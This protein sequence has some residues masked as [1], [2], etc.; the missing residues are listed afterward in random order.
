MIESNDETPPS[1]KTRVSGAKRL[2][3]NTAT[4]YEVQAC[5]TN[6]ISTR[7]PASQSSPTT[8]QAKSAIVSNPRFSTQRWKLWNDQI[9]PLKKNITNKVDSRVNFFHGKP[10][11][12]GDRNISITLDTIH[13]RTDTIKAH[14]DSEGVVSGDQIKNQARD[15][16]NYIFDE[17]SPPVGWSASVENQNNIGQRN[18]KHVP[19][20]LRKSSSRPD[21][22]FNANWIECRVNE[23]REKNENEQTHRSAFA[24]MNS[25]KSQH[26][27]LLENSKYLLTPNIFT[28]TIENKTKKIHKSKIDYI[29]AK[30]KNC[31]RPQL[32]SHNI[33]NDNTKHPM[34]SI[35]II[36]ETKNEKDAQIYTISIP[37]HTVPKSRYSN[38]QEGVPKQNTKPHK[39]CRRIT[40]AGERHYNNLKQLPL[41]T[42]WAFNHPLLETVDGGPVIEG[43]LEGLPRDN[44]DGPNIPHDHHIPGTNYPAYHH[45]NPQTMHHSDSLLTDINSE[46]LAHKYS[47][48]EHDSRVPSMAG[49]WDSF[50]RNWQMSNM[51][52]DL[53]KDISLMPEINRL[54]HDEYYDLPCANINDAVLQNFEVLSFE[55]DDFNE[56]TTAFDNNNKRHWVENNL[57]SNFLHMPQPAKYLAVSKE[58]DKAAIPRRI[59]VYSSTKNPSTLTESKSSH[60][61]AFFEQQPPPPYPSNKKEKSAVIE[62]S[63]E[64]IKFK[65]TRDVFHN[66]GNIKNIRPIAIN[67][68]GDFPVNNYSSSSTIPAEPKPPGTS[69]YPINKP[70]SSI[71]SQACEIVLADGRIGLFVP[72]NCYHNNH[73]AYHQTSN[74]NNC[75][76]QSTFSNNSMYHNN[77]QRHSS[78]LPNDMSESGPFF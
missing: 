59:P 21:I 35:G 44:Y 72:K 55:E 65:T 68:G 26:N 46:V 77:C 15:L 74:N 71:D 64:E 29:R 66:T 7:S 17:H 4:S 38:Y 47:I 28:S 75:P 12:T 11:N 40:N 76:N 45:F 23:N 16:P 57:P 14:H 54:T 43:G 61:M 52:H 6:A 73:M 24:K 60:K 25:E 51:S 69:N 8:V 19:V 1:S 2:S 39:P 27:Q 13:N 3:K 33:I 58:N 30:S 10:I 53:Q 50:P 41:G 9:L 67:R 5:S 62:K 48:K 34:K 22:A 70:Q 37:D 20:I 63:M 49:R 32:A 18:V 31:S 78:V 56:S 42:E 36:K